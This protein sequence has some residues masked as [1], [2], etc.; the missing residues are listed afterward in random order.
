MSRVSRYCYDMFHQFVTVIA[1]VGEYLKDLTLPNVIKE[2]LIN[3][4][5]PL[6]HS[7]PAEDPRKGTG[8][9]RNLCH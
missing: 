5:D 3:L 2:H 8:W 9:I 7:F 4:A 6:Q 1:D